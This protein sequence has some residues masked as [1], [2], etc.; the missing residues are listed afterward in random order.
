LALLYWAQRRSGEAEPLYKRTV[1]IYDKALGPDHT[2]VGTALNKL[3]E[4][5]ESQG[6]FTEAEP[7]YKRSLAIHEKALGSEHPDVALNNL[8][9]P[10]DVGGNPLLDGPDAR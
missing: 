4:V 2:P 3:A 10:P 6:R 8:A 5:Y 1:A 7:L 9:A